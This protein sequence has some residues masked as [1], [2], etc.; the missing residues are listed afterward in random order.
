MELN[1][2]LC[3]NECETTPDFLGKSAS[4]SAT[5]LFPISR[6]MNILW[7]DWALCTGVWLVGVYMDPH[8]SIPWLFNKSLVYLTISIIGPKL[9]RSLQIW[10]RF[11]FFGK[12]LKGNLFHSNSMLWNINWKSIPFKLIYI[13]WSTQKQKNQV[14]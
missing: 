12:D 13:I 1:L 3:A 9:C 2:K 5:F 11:G 10:V 14:L 4:D 6:F 8:A 7:L